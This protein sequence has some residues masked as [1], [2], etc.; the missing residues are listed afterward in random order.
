MWASFPLGHTGHSNSSPN[1]DK[2]LDVFNQ[3]IKNIA[4]YSSHFWKALCYGMDNYSLI[5]RG[6]KADLSIGKTKY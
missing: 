3:K 5:K 4:H 2:D 6:R 1:K